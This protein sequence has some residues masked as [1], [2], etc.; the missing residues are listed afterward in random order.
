MR[1]NPG[2]KPLLCH[3]R[4]VTSQQKIETIWEWFAPG[5][6][7]QLT[8]DLNGAVKLTIGPHSGIVNQVILRTIKLHF[9]AP[10]ATVKASGTPM[11]AGKEGCNGSPEARRIPWHQKARV[12]VCEIL[13]NWRK[14]WAVWKEW[15]VFLW[16]PFERKRQ[17]K[18]YRYQYLY[19]PPYKLWKL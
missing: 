7:R 10:A 12:R 6:W 8:E 13:E 9:P 2:I 4:S 3:T 11:V 18:G 15:L 16:A 19:L 14:K 5:R 1:S 17:K